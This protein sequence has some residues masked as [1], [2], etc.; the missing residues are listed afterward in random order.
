MTSPSWEILIQIAAIEI[1]LQDAGFIVK[2]AFF[3]VDTCNLSKLDIIAKTLC[4]QIS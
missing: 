1:Q 2:K 4:F 3:F